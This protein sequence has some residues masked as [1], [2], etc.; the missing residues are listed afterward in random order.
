MGY[1]LA[2]LSV[3][4]K[5]FDMFITLYD[6]CEDKLCGRK[7]MYTNCRDCVLWIWNNFGEILPNTILVVYLYFMLIIFELILLNT[8]KDSSWPGEYLCL[9]AYSTDPFP[10]NPVNLWVW[11][12]IIFL[13]SSIWTLLGFRYVFFLISLREI[14][15][16]VELGML[17]QSS[18]V[19]LRIALY[20]ELL[21]FLRVA[22]VVSVTE[23]AIF[24]H[25]APFCLL[26][27]EQWNMLHDS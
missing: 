17:V 13:I 23:Y 2:V 1:M 3:F 16:K 25:S 22:T 15:V 21:S 7:H 18:H 8:G 4:T 14:H 10:L 20:P 12:P 24:Y 5:Y 9:A 6:A 26:A 19:R 27:L 11:W